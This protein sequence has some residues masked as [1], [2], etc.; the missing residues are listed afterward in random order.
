MGR[1]FC[2]IYSLIFKMNF[3]MAEENQYENQDF[4]RFFFVLLPRDTSLSKRSTEKLT[5]EPS[6]YTDILSA[7]DICLVWQLNNKGI[8]SPHTV[9]IRITA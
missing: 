1:N 7:S 3:T 4:S 9:E 2:S 8:T 6:I 5:S